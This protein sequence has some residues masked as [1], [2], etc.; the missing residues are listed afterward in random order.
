MILTTQEGKKIDTNK[1]IDLSIPLSNDDENPLAWYVKPPSFEPVMDDG[2]VGS[3]KKGG[4]VNF[5][6]ISFNPHGHGT[7]TEC[8]GHITP[9][10]YSIN[11]HL[12]QYF[13]KA[14]LISVKPDKIGGDE[15]ITPRLLTELEKYSEVEALV[16]RTLPNDVDKKSKNYS[17]TN[18]PYISEEC[19]SIVNA[20]NVK[21]LLIDLPSVDKESD[22]GQLTFHH[23]FWDVPSSPRFDRTITELI[24]VPNEVE[25]GTYLLN[26]HVAPFENDAAPSRPV[27]YRY[28]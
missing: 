17:S 11:E 28:I 4:P 23:G 19:L 22:G 21:H 3:V 8:L 7:H 6:N 1:G 18:P 16:I 13:F 9:T 14:V 26:L 5:R 27:L 12:N 2:W 20:I 10:V 25:D 24:F 15:V